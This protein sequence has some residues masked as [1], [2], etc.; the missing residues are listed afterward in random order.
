M[1]VPRADQVTLTYRVGPTT[2]PAVDSVSLKVPSGAAIGIACESGSGKT[3]FARMLVGVVEP[4]SG[5]VTWDGSPL[6]RSAL[7]VSDQASILNLLR[8]LQRRTGMALVFV[9]HN[10]DVIR[11]LYR[12]VV[13]QPHGQLVDAVPRLARPH[14]RT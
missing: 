13:V 7:D 6:E 4:T 2:R 8:A 10:L 9:S 14:T 3:G 1:T 11:Y 5:T 12:D